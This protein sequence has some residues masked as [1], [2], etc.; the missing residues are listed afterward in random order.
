MI[1]SK[2][3]IC[4][5]GE[6]AYARAIN[7]RKGKY[8]MNTNS[9]AAKEAVRQLPESEK[10]IFGYSSKMQYLSG[11]YGSVLRCDRQGYELECF[12]REKE[13]CVVLRFALPFLYEDEQYRY[14]SGYLDCINKSHKVISE[15]VL[16]DFIFSMDQDV[17]VRRRI[18]YKDHFLTV[19]DL[20]Q[21][22]AEMIVDAELYYPVIRAIGLGAPVPSDIGELPWIVQ[23]IFKNA[24]FGLHDFPCDTKEPSRLYFEEYMKS[25]AFADEE[26]KRLRQRNKPDTSTAKR[27]DESCSEED[28]EFRRIMSVFDDDPPAASKIQAQKDRTEPEDA[29]EEHNIEAGGE[30]L[31]FCGTM[32]KKKKHSRFDDPEFQEKYYRMMFVD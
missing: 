5:K 9:D 18:D 28:E 8:D 13:S 3:S 27:N 29:E 1:S 2:E 4:S 12:V 31:D 7:G 25:Q 24:A 20:E 19:K 11:F 21:T 22:L 14:L 16:D 23:F 10:Y 6:I 26:E 15:F 32:Q 17:I 30:N